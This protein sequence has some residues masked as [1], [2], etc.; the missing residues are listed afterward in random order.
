MTQLHLGRFLSLCCPVKGRD[1]PRGSGKA[2]CQEGRDLANL[3]VWY[4]YVVIT[5]VTCSAYAWVHCH[6]A[7]NVLIS[8]IGP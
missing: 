7:P 8:I 1:E 6:G 2:Y 5:R 3:R 4:V